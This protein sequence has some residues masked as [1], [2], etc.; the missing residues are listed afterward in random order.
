MDGRA[1][2]LLVTAAEILRDQ[3]SSAELIERFRAA[4]EQEGRVTSAIVLSILAPGHPLLQTRLITA[5][6]IGQVHNDWTMA[7]EFAARLEPPPQLVAT[8][9]GLAN[10][11]TRATWDKGVPLLALIERVMHDPATRDALRL[12]LDP[13]GDLTP[14]A[15]CASAAVLSAAGWLDA[16]GLDLCAARLIDEQANPSVP[17]A[18]LDIAT[19]ET[20]PLTHVLTDLLQARSGL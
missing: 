3:F 5:L 17:V 16:E 6:E 18:V 19:D 9:H 7:V 14:S 12:S 11:R 13:G 15:F 8:L 10:R 1:L 20:R 4:L 2:P